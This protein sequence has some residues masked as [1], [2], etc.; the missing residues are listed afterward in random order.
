MLNKQKSSHRAIISLN[1][2]MFL[3]DKIMFKMRIK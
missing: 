1:I 3:R 2:M